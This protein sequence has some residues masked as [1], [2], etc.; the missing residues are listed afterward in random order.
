MASH[1]RQELTSRIETEEVKKT[2]PRKEGRTLRA[3][4]VAV[5]SLLS[6]LFVAPAAPGVNEDTSVGPAPALAPG[7]APPLPKPGPLAEPR[8]STQV[9]FPTVLTKY[10]ISP[11]T[12]RPA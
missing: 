9:G 1:S 3:T 11:S 4:S 6:S 2:R 5:L 7:Q 12:L 10:V 8:S